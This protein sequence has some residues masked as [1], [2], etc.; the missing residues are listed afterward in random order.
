MQTESH[1]STRP[2]PSSQANAK[3]SIGLTQEDIDFIRQDMF[4]Y[5]RS[6]GYDYDAALRTA[7]MAAQIL[8]E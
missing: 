7:N 8:V 1:S 4:E 3:N 2:E 5:S 6:L